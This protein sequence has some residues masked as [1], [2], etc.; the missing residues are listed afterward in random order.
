MIS[1]RRLL[2]RIKFLAG[3]LNG[4]WVGVVILGFLWLLL[5]LYTALQRSSSIYSAWVDNYD[6]KQDVPMADSALRGYDYPLAAGAAGSPVSIHKGYVYENGHGVHNNTYYTYPDYYDSNP[7]QYA[8]SSYN[9]HLAR[10]YPAN[11][12]SSTSGTA[13]PPFSNALYGPPLPGDSEKIAVQTPT[14]EHS[15]SQ[16]PHS[17]DGRSP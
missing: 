15:N 9:P 17:H 7:Q 11:H 10:S 8:S 5:L 16:P 12:R 3:L 6:Y 13:T 2:Q 1:K 4:V 14:T